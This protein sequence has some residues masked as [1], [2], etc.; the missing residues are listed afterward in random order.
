[1][2][3]I[4]STTTTTTI[5]ST[6]TPSPAAGP[7]LCSAPYPSSNFL[8]V[9]SYSTS[10]CGCEND[11]STGQGV[12]VH[13]ECGA[14]CSADSDCPSGET[15]ID[16]TACNSSGNTCTSYTVCYNSASASRMFRRKMEG[17]RARQSLSTPLHVGQ[18]QTA[19]QLAGV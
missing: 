12:C 5:T 10:S 7:L 4:D 14:D 1:M 18:N 6:T 13:E 15:C 16:Q 11:V 8:T 17:L 2:T 3:E 9:C 19:L